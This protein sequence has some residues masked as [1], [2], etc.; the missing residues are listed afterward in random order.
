MWVIDRFTV[1]EAME[2]GLTMAEE[3]GVS[4]RRF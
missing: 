3:A 1:T 2:S 4:V